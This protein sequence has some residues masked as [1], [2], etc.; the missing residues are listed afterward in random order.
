MLKLP[1][2][3]ERYEPAK[4]QNVCILACPFIAEDLLPSI[5]YASAKGSLLCE[6]ARKHLIMSLPLTGDDKRLQS[7]PMLILSKRRSGKAKPIASLPDP[8]D[9]ACITSKDLSV[10]ALHSALQAAVQC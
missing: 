7:P 1:L 9:S 6:K 5:Q 10:H 8:S 3:D 4:T 2:P